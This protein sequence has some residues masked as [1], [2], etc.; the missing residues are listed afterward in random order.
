MNRFAFCLACAVLALPLPRVATVSADEPKLGI[1]SPAP[2]LEVKEFVKGNAVKG[3]DKNKIYVV[4]FWATWCGPC[5]V[6]IPHLTELQMKNK[7]VVFI[8]VS[9][10]EDDPAGV[11]AFVKKMGD[12]M[13]YRVAMDLIPEK[14]EADDGKMALGWM[15]AAGLKGIPAAFVVNG[16]GVIAWVGH[17]SGLAKPLERIVAGKW[18]VAAAALR[19]KLRHEIEAKLT[20]PGNATPTEL[21]KF[22][23]DKLKADAELEES[24]GVSKLGL[25]LRVEDGRDA[26]AAYADRLVE[27]V[28][29]KEKDELI[30]VA[31]EILEVADDAKKDASVIAVALKAAKRVDAMAESKDLRAAF[32][33]AHVHR[34][35]KDTPNAITEMKRAIKLAKDADQPNPKIIAALEKQLGEFEKPTPK[36]EKDK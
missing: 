22:L 20:K 3:F 11:T 29:P 10:W 7:D 8:G 36:K 18:D 26:A 13:N 27:K 32:L 31:E 12:K 6:S 14:G 9:V 30:A 23:D 24:F 34:A 33:L 19:E 21:V 15:K 2:K 28:F 1:G 35:N 17:P 5:K 16:D 4:E 25:L